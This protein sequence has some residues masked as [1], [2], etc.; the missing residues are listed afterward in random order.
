MGVKI[1]TSWLVVSGWLPG[2][3]LHFV[4]GYVEVPDSRTP[5]GTVAETL[6]LITRHVLLPQSSKSCF[7][8]GRFGILFPVSCL[9]V[10]PQKPS[11]GHFDG[12][13]CTVVGCVM[14]SHDLDR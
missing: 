3:D 4:G 10:L 6:G 1:S 13:G 5:A 2:E 14:I 7:F 12:L 8:G 11:S 9:L